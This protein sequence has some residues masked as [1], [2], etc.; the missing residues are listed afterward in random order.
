MTGLAPTPAAGVVATFLSPVIRVS[1]VGLVDA[2][3][4]FDNLIVTYNEF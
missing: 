1:G 2:Y 4:Y 3:G